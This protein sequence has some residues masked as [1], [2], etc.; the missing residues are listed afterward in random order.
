[1]NEPTAMRVSE[2]SAAVSPGVRRTDVVGAR[3]TAVG[4]ACGRDASERKV[5][6]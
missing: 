2:R 3:I 6:Q 4:S 1:M 5:T